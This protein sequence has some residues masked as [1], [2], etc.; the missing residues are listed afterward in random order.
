MKLGITA[1]SIPI[2]H[3]LPLQAAAAIIVLRFFV[4]YSTCLC[5]LLCT[6]REKKR[7]ASS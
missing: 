3:G 1:G 5:S 4:R 6:G 2:V 7:S